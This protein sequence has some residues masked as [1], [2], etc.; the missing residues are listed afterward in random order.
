MADKKDKWLPLEANPEVMNKYVSNLG[1]VMSYQ[2]HD[3]FGLDPDLLCMLPQPC[4]A[5][6]LLFPINKNVRESESKEKERIEKDGQ[7]V[8]PSVYFVKQTIGNACGTIGL[9]HAIGNCQD[10]ISFK[11][12]FLKT[13]FEKTQS[14][15]PKQRAD[16]LEEDDS[17][18][19]AHEASAQEGDTAPPA[20]EE[21]VN[22]HFISIVHKDGCV[23]ELDGRKDYPI[24]H[25]KSTTDTFLVD[26]AKVCKSFMDRDPTELHFTVVA[27]VAAD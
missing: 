19:E 18:S 12:G 21:D 2:F 22:L 24:N 10:K 26:A 15:T 7:L 6:L 11:D 1:M 3:V 13:F 14:L 8:S 27:L 17:I 25:G 4:I 9:L 20:P 5:L 23:Y 16:Y